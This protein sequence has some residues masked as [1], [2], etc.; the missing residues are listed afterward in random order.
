MLIKVDEDYM[1]V[2]TGF[3][4]NS[5]SSSYIITQ[6][7]K[8]SWYYDHSDLYLLSREEKMRIEQ[9]PADRKTETL[10]LTK[11]V[12]DCDEIP[13]GTIEY[14]DGGHGG[15]YDEENYVEVKSHIWLRKEHVVTVATEDDELDFTVKDGV[16]VSTD[17]FWYDL[18]DGGYLHPE[19]ILVNQKTAEKVNEA[20]LT[21]VAFKEA[22]EE[23][24]EGFIR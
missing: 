20:I 1:K 16:E 22:C 3:V 6:K 9:I 2:R 17:D 5:S 8:D 13:K 15:P 23:Q 4:S 12:N 11:H 14:V 7:G 21:L 18:T 19:R 24:I 10:Y